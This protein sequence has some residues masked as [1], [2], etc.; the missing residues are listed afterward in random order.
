MQPQFTAIETMIMQ[1]EA[2]TKTASSIAFLLD[3]SVDD[4]KWFLRSIA[5]D[6]GISTRQ[7]QIEQKKAA[8]PV[9]QKVPKP[10]K[11]KAPKIISREVKFVPSAFEL[12]QR[13][14]RTKEAADRF[15]TKAV[16]YSQLITVKVDNRTHIYIKP[17]QDPQAAIDR[18]HK[19]LAGTKSY[20]SDRA[21]VNGHSIRQDQLNSK[22]KNH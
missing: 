4:V 7:S 21:R 16:D 19:S 22:Q 12:Q 1:R 10:K 8:R 15:Q 18:F 3:R 6:G 2:A 14:K 13:A 11:Q 17:G 9:K 5:E 20:Y